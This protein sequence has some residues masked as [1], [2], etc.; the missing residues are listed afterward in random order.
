MTA[1][2]LSNGGDSSVLEQIVEALCRHGILAAHCLFH[3]S[4]WNIAFAT[5]SMCA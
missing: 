4:A 3:F 2:P 5:P 1:V